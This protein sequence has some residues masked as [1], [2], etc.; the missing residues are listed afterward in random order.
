VSLQVR[1][2]TDD[3]ARAIADVQVETWRATYLDVMPADVLDALDVEERERMWRRFAAADGF[4]VFVAEREERIVG[5][6]S[7]GACRDLPGTGELFAIYVAPHFQRTGAGLALMEAAVA[8]LAE[9]WDEARA[10]GRDRKPAGATLLRAIR[11]DRG[12]RA[13]RHEPDRRG[14]SGDSLPAVRPDAALG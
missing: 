3:D 14:R 10:L 9:R 5:F 13:R 7:V 4:A 12:R 11:L 6:A 8:W 1:R 2:A